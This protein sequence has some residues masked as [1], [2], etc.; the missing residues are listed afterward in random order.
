MYVGVW[1]IDDIELS[2]ATCVK[3]LYP[4]CKEFYTGARYY[5]SHSGVYIKAQYN[6]YAGGIYD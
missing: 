3:R 1:T 4:L 6:V 5:Y 2:A